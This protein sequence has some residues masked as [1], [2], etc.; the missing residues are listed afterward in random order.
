MHIQQNKYILG[1]DKIKQEFIEHLSAPG[2]KTLD[3]W[4]LDRRR[5]IKTHLPF[6]LLPPSVME[7]KC[8]IIYV[9]RNPKDVAVSYYHLNR[10]YRTQGYCG[11]FTRYWNYFSRGLNPWLPYYS[12][13]KE[14]YT[15]RNLPNIL[16]LN[17]EEM[18]SNLNGV[19]LKVAAFLDITISKERLKDLK[20]HLDIKNFRENP[21]VNGSEMSDIGVLLKGEAG[22]VRNG[23]NGKREE[24]VSD[25]ELKKCVDEWIEKNIV[26]P[27]A[28]AILSL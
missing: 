14:A 9:M 18:V 24:L 2:Y 23:G 1:Y 15:H 26:K 4:P 16:V 25:V 19:I 8:K 21:A 7:N 3:R 17:Y 20:E 27:T 13:I 12:H 6:S 10:L 28:K 5:F 22:F 11:D